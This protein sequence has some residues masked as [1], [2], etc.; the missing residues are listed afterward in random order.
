MA[1]FF[2][3]SFFFLGMLVKF[4]DDAFDE[5]AY[6]RK[7]ALV[8]APITAIFWAYVMSLSPAAALLLTA[9]TIGVLVKGKID[10]IAFIMAVLCIYLVYFF[11]GDWQFVFNIVYLIPLI[12]I[13]IGGVIDEVGNDFVDKNNIYKKGFSGKLVHWFFEYRFVMKIF[14]L[15]FALIGTYHILF[16]V[17]FFFWDLGYETIMHYSKYV[18]RR[19]KFY[20]NEKTNGY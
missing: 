17:A 5:R 10:N 1:L 8:L 9:I 11:I 20:Y 13:S 18:L 4:I 15:S 7:V 14:V 19:R 12:I 2:V 16:F 3:V 6:S